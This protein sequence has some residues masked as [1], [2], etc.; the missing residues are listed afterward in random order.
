MTIQVVFWLVLVVAFVAAE[1]AT[2]QLVSVWF[3][4]GAL[5]AMFLGTKA[6]AAPMFVQFLVF[7]VVSALLFLVSRPI[8]R[9]LA[10]SSE[11]LLTNSERAI[12][13]IVPVLRDIE[14]NGSGEIKVNGLAW[15]A[16]SRTGEPIR[17]GEFVKVYAIE[18]VKLIVDRN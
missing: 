18:G 2:T 12:G 11:K 3:A 14:A 7:A 4:V 6:I 8:A 9:K 16:V 5:V 17:A 15:T 13:A 1:A 10:S